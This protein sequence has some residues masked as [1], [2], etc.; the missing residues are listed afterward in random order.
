MRKTILVVDDDLSIRDSVIKVLKS[1]G[2]DTV[3]AAG[4]LEALTRLLTQSI[5][6]VLLDIGL[7]NQNGWETCRNIAREHTA[8]PIIVITGQ[9]G[10]SKLALEAGATAF[11]EK[12]LE[13]DQLLEMIEDLQCCHS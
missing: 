1:A 12:P 7:P 2:Y 9:T 4:G 13:A 3:P 6:V 5:D 10:L 8:V 11:M